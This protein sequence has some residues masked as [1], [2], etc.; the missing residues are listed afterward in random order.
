MQKP[1]IS[2][3]QKA[4]EARAKADRFQA[5]QQSLQTRTS[6]LARAFATRRSLFAGTPATARSR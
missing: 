2:A 6:D 4:A 1:K 3:E 5:I